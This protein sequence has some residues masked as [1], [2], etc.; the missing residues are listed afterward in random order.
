MLNPLGEELWRD[1]GEYSE[2]PELL[3]ILLLGYCL[4]RFIGSNMVNSKVTAVKR[5]KNKET[6]AVEII[7]DI[8]G[9]GSETYDF[10]NRSRWSMVSSSKSS[11]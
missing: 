9:V 2:R 1:E 6:G 10:G 11:V 8:E 7:L 4:R 3:G 5:E